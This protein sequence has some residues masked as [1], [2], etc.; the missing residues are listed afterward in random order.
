MRNK[1]LFFIF[2]FLATALFGQVTIPYLDVE[3]LKDSTTVG[4]NLLKLANPSAVRFARINADNTV[5]LLDAAGLRSAIAAGDVGLGA[6]NDFTGLNTS[7]FLT[8][9]VL[10]NISTVTSGSTISP[11]AQRVY[12]GAISGSVTL[13]APAMTAGQTFV[14]KDIAISSAGTMTFSGFAPRRLSSLVTSTIP[15]LALANGV[16]SFVVSYDGT[17][18]T[19]ADTI[20]G[21]FTT[22]QITD[23]DADVALI[24]NSDARI[25]TQKATKAYADA[26]AA[27]AT[28]AALIGSHTTPNT[29]A[30]AVTVTKAVTLVFSNTTTAWTLPAAATWTGKVVGFF[31]TGT[32]ILTVDPNGSEVVVREGVAQPGG[33]TLTLSGIG[34]N[35]V[36][37]MSDGVRIITLGSRGTLAA[38]S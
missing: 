37:V 20:S 1:I 6:A 4:R 13:V 26:A 8:K 18:Y 2:G 28:T 31:T 22:S 34:G 25:A 36:W 33:V 16:H 11:A 12:N 10:A 3:E 30:G 9:P 17:N 7:V 32:N 14:L 24:A 15:N 5:T 27:A 29:T 21:T 35:F 23:L 38:G 19:L